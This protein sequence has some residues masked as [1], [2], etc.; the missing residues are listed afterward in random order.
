[1][2]P[3]DPAPVTLTRGAS[4]RWTISYKSDKIQCESDDDLIRRVF[5]VVERVN[6]EVGDTLKA[7]SEVAP[8]VPPAFPT[9]AAT[10]RPFEY[11]RACVVCGHGFFTDDPD[12]NWCGCLGNP[13]A[14]AR[15]RRVI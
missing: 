5:E 1:L 4:P 7:G 15:T 12:E 3:T 9:N 14:R 8:Y 11:Q 6:A 13:N 10:G 2:T